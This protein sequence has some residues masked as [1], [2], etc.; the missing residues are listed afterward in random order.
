MEP[1]DRPKST[2]PIWAV[3]AP[4][5]SLMSGVRVTHDEIESPGRKKS[6]NSDCRHRRVARPS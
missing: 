4:N 5:W 2:S 3:D 1:A 6:R